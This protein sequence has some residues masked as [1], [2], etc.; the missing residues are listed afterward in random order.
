[1]PSFAIAL[2]MLACLCGPAMAQ[3]AATAAPGGS[4]A[5]GAVGN[6]VGGNSVVSGSIAT[7]TT[8]MP[9]RAGGAPSAGGAAPG[10]TAG[11]VPILCPAN[12]PMIATEIAGTNLSCLP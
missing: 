8:T 6:V 7:P 12:D 5:T 2:F 9:T 4:L 11:S 10:A 3:V 1:M